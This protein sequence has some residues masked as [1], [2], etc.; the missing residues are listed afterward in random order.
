MVFRILILTDP[1]KRVAVKV[2][3][4]S[5]NS[6]FGLDV[7]VGGEWHIFI[8]QETKEKSRATF[9]KIENRPPS[10]TPLSYQNRFL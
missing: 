1:L 10:K 3:V 5:A 8:Y 6:R 9:R 7:R 2:I 4:E